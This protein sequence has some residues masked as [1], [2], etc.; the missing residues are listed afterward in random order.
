MHGSD[1][2]WRSLTLRMCQLAVS[3]TRPGNGFAC[4]RAPTGFGSSWHST[5]ELSEFQLRGEHHHAYEQAAVNEQTPPSPPFYV[6]RASLQDDGSLGAWIKLTVRGSP[7]MSALYRAIDA[8]VRRRCVPV[9]YGGTFA[10]TRE[11][12]ESHPVGVWRAIATLL[13]RGDN[14]Q[15]GS[16]VERLWA[17]LLAPPLSARQEAMLSRVKAINGSVVQ[18][19][20]SYAGQLQSCHCQERARSRGLYI[21]RGYIK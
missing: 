19:P 2:Q 11:R 1:A 13:E 17:A 12:V 6:A 21:R 18:M 3:A 20:S 14:I 8:A 15:E 7:S 16:F 5:N 9:C 10:A 4:G